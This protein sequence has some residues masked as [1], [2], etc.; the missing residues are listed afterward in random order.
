[1]EVAVLVLLHMSSSC[2]IYVENRKIK[3]AKVTPN[4]FPR[5]KLNLKDQESK[6]TL[7]KLKPQLPWKGHLSPQEHCQPENDFRMMLELP[8]P[9]SYLF[10]HCVGV[11]YP[12]LH[13]F[14][15][16]CAEL[17]PPDRFPFPNAY[18]QS[19]LDVRCSELVE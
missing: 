6:N 16:R 14:G 19:L 15:G 1:M 10:E 5:P 4:P 18:G 17:P 9:S 3:K 13:C 12:A 11:D 7:P 8:L 2:H